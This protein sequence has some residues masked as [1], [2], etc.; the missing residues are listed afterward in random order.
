MISASEMTSKNLRRMIQ[1]EETAP[2]AAMQDAETLPTMTSLRSPTTRTIIAIHQNNN[3]F[4]V[5]RDQLADA[6]ATRDAYQRLTDEGESMM[7]HPI[8]GD[9]PVSPSSLR[10]SS[11]S[12]L[13]NRGAEAMG[14]PWSMADDAGAAAI[15]DVDAPTA[16]D[17]DA[18]LLSKVVFTYPR[19][20]AG[21]VLDPIGN[22]TSPAR[23][24]LDAERNRKERSPDLAATDAIDAPIETFSSPEQPVP[25]EMGPSP[26]SFTITETSRPGT[27]NGVLPPPQLAVGRPDSATDSLVTRRAASPAV[28]RPALS[29][30]ELL[31]EQRADL[32]AADTSYDTY[33]HEFGH[34]IKLQTELRRRMDTLLTL[35]QPAITGAPEE[36]G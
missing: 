6:E 18:E 7:N 10:V 24:R 30:K 22:V 27:A 16:L 4:N 14:D 31:K 32:D 35:D 2:L 13:G 15:G 19:D 5:L 21:A 36:K 8:Y 3:H 25:R 12:R 33:T 20:A 34:A 17:S 29:L 9:R 26:A 1:L 23:I 11:P 28:A